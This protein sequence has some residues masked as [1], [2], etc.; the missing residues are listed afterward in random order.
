MWSVVNQTIEQTMEQKKAAGIVSVMGIVFVTVQP[1][2]PGR[3]VIRKDDIVLMIE[4]FFA[5]I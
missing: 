3:I 1:G 2:A 4:R 5:R